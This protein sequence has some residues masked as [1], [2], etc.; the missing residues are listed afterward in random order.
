MSRIVGSRLLV[1]MRNALVH[2]YMALFYLG[3]TNYVTKKVGKFNWF[4]VRTDAK[5]RSMEVTNPE[6]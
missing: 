3:W 6:T 5:L 2:Y 1:F 4:H